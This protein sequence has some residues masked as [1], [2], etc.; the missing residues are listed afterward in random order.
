MVGHLNL[1]QKVAT[2][3]LRQVLLMQVQE[4]PSRILPCREKLHEHL[5]IREKRP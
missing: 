5:A 1:R 4:Q 2:L 3:T